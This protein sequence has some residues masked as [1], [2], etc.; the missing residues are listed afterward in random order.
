MKIFSD[1]LHMMTGHAYKHV[2]SYQTDAMVDAKYIL[3]SYLRT[4]VWVEEF[5]IYYRELGT[6]LYLPETKDVTNLYY[7]R[8]YDPLG[9]L[10]KYVYTENGYTCEELDID[11]YIKE[12][13]VAHV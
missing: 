12:E 8:N 10:Y 11:T 6:A 5:A 4:G 1:L 7:A 2:K 9:T 13:E 3:D